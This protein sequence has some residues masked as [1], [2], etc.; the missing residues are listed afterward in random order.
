M[1][2]EGGIGL[3]RISQE[4]TRREKGRRAVGELCGCEGGGGGVGEAVLGEI[5]AVLVIAVLVVAAVLVV[6]GVVLLVLLAD[7][8]GFP[9]VHVGEVHEDVAFGLLV[10]VDVKHGASG[11]AVEGIA[12]LGLGDFLAVLIVE[13]CEVLVV[14]VLDV[15]PLDLEEALELEGVVLPPEGEGLLMEAGLESGHALEHS[16]LDCAEEEVSVDSVLLLPLPQLF[17]L[18]LVFDGGGPDAVLD[19]LSGREGTLWTLSS[20]P[21]RMT[22]PVAWDSVVRSMGELMDLRWGKA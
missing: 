12:V 7:V 15:D 9:F 16:A 10:V 21:L 3:G 6:V 2:H 14:D 19:G 22:T 1:R 18:G 13:A 8:E 11:G 20:L 17:Q 4:R 5:V